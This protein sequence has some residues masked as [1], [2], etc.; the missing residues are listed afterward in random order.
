MKP[1]TMQKVFV[2]WFIVLTFM[3]SYNFYHNI[4]DDTRQTVT[5]ATL[6]QR[7]R[8]DRDIEKLQLEVQDLKLK[9]CFDELK[10]K[11]QALPYQP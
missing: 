6:V 4:I 9:Q 10:L 3:A 5:E 7:T 2:V 1:Q 8:L 11:N